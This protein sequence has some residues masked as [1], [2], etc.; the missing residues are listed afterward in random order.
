MSLQEPAEATVADRVTNGRKDEGTALPW[1]ELGSDGGGCDAHR[2]RGNPG[3]A[4]HRHDGGCLTVGDGSVEEH[5]THPMAELA[6][7]AG[8]DRGAFEGQGIG[9]QGGDA[10]EVRKWH[11]FRHPVRCVDRN[12]D[13]VHC[14]FLSGYG[15]SGYGLS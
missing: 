4:P 2:A 12:S 14:A 7:R 13:S 9:E 6:E 10:P 15:L 11:Q 1:P 5:E 3:V 8:I